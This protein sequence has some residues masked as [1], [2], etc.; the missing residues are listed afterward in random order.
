[1]CTPSWVISVWSPRGDVTLHAGSEGRA[2]RRLLMRKKKSARK[3][4]LLSP[5]DRILQNFDIIL[6]SYSELY[7]TCVENISQEKIIS[8]VRT[9]TEGTNLLSRILTCYSEFPED[10]YLLQSRY[11]QKIR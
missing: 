10:T 5:H 11:V 3:K 9:T 2:R 4:R 1:M 7:L 6:V 8:G